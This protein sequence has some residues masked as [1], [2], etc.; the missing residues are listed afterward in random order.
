[1]I[2]PLPY[3]QDTYLTRVSP[4]T[5]LPSYAGTMVDITPPWMHGLFHLHDVASKPLGEKRQE[6]PYIRKT[7]RLGDKIGPFPIIA[8]KPNQI[9]CARQDKNL[10]FYST[11]RLHALPSGDRYVSCTTRVAF[12]NKR[13]KAYFGLLLKPFHHWLLPKLMKKLSDAPPIHILDR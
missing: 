11:Y 8:I 7:P 12:K 1:M 13:G 5:E 10:D 6:Y 3:Y 4:D 2:S 9:V